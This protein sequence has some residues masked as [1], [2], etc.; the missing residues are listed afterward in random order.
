VMHWLVPLLLLNAGLIGL[1]V[2]LI[3]RAVRRLHHY[4]GMIE[5]LKR[6][7]SRLRELLKD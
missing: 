4:D 7:H 5:E 3:V 1:G 2:Y 6:R